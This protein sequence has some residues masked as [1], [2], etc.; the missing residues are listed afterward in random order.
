M[1]LIAYRTS[2]VTIN[3]AT[4]PRDGPGSDDH[5]A[6]DGSLRCSANC[7]CISHRFIRGHGSN[8]DVWMLPT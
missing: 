3:N 7:D 8:L 5:D 1:R 6:C 4:P 2:C